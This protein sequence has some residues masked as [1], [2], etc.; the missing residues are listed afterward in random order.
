VSQHWNPSYRVKLLLTISGIVLITGAAVTWVSH[1]AARQTVGA[2]VETLFREASFR[3]VAVTQSHVS[4]AEPVVHAMSRLSE[5]LVELN[6]S[7]ELLE[8]LHSL[9][10]ANEGLTWLSYADEAGRFTGVYRYDSQQIR[11]MQSQVE[12]EHSLEIQWAYDTDGALHE[13]SLDDQSTYDP[14]TRPFYVAAKDAG[15]LTWLDPYRFV[16]DYVPGVTCAAP[17]YDSQGELLGVFTADFTLVALSEFLDSW[18]ISENARVLLFTSDGTL[19]SYPS[20]CR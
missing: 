13:V 6:H 16:P 1:R 9:L 18:Q 20:Q 2:M 12:G 11:V 10:E 5:T 14:R 4:K 8:A 17:V 7:S 19:L 3:A 15:E